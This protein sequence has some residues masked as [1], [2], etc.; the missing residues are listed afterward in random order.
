MKA[1]LV[2]SILLAV[3]IAASPQDP[4]KVDPSHYRVLFE[5]AHIRVLEYRDKP[6]D[7]APLHSHPAYM[8]YVTG[9]GKT[10]VTLPDGKASTDENAGSEFD[11]HPPTQHATENVG[12]TDTQELLVEFKGAT[13]PCSP[14][15]RDVHSSNVGE[16][17]RTENE[18]LKLQDALIAA[19]IRRDTA[20]LDRILADEYTFINDDAG[21]MVNK[22]QI[23]DSFQSGRDREITAYIRHDDRVRTYGDV[24]VLTYRYQSTETYKGRENGGEFL[25]TRIFAKQD[26]RWR[27][28]GGQETRVSQPEPSVGNPLIG[29]WRLVSTEAILPDSSSKPFPEFGA[30]PVGYLMYDATG[31]MC[32]TLAN[33]NPPHWADPAKPTDA[34]RA[35]THKAMEAYCGTYE[36]REK[37]S[38]V[39][40]RPELAEWPHYIGSDQVRNYRL[41]G[42]RLILS[43][44]EII[45]NGG[46]RRSQITWERVA[47]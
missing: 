46:R 36:V 8:T 19:Y 21:G 6:G 38:Q 37:E 42:A 43:L 35:L 24:A 2:C 10:K 22:R 28:V 25:V 9:A 41:N 5:N 23:L 32:V 31:H 20:A 14:E 29:T 11:C 39:I 4:V 27:I 12:S 33:P 3:S 45:P 47:E 34:E 7:K 44:E 26:G 17:S 1:I 15:Q 13:N 40:H 16:S 18:I 30:H